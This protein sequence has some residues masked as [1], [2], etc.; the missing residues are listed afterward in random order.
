MPLTLLRPYDSGRNLDQLVALLSPSVWFKFLDVGGT[1]VTDSSGNGRNGTAVPGTGTVTLANGTATITAGGRITI[2]DNAAFSVPAKGGFTTVGIYTKTAGSYLW[3]KG[4]NSSANY[5]WQVTCGHTTGANP[6]ATTHSS[7]GGG[8][9][10]CSA[11]GLTGF[12]TAHD[13]IVVASFWDQSQDAPHM[14]SINGQSQKPTPSHTSGTY[15]DGTSQIQLGSRQD[16]AT[17]D[18]AGVFKYWFAF[19]YSMDPMGALTLALAANRSGFDIPIA[20]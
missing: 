18:F 2:A 10:T 7:A 9:S 4:G 16:Q 14:V 8:M 20:A 3:T 11:S 15:A 13:N 12:D 6:S 1:T 19:P 5:E 17:A